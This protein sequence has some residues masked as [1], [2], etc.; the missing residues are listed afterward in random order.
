MINSHFCHQL[1]ESCIQAYEKESKNFVDF[2]YKTRTGD[3]YNEH[4]PHEIIRQAFQAKAVVGKNKIER[5]LKQLDTDGGCQ[6]GSTS[7]NSASV[8]DI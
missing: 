2:L 6:I 5:L 3:S 4:A 1:C 7:R 8:C